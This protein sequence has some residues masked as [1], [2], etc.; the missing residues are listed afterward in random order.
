MAYTQTDLD[1]IRLAIIEFG[2]G[3]RAGRV[4]VGDKMIEY[5]TVTMLDLER[6]ETRIL[7]GINTSAGRRSCFRVRTSKG[8]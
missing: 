3:R 7:N 4:S 8:L 5:A 2:K 1:A 6:L